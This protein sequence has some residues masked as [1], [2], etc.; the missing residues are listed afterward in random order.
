MGYNVGFMD[1]TVAHSFPSWLV[2]YRPLV[3][4]NSLVEEINGIYHSFDAANYDRDHLEIRLLWPGLWAGMIKQLPERTGWRILDFGCGTGFEAEQVLKALGSRIEF[5]AAYDPSPAMLAQAQCRVASPKMIV[6]DNLEATLADGPFNLLIT[7]SVLHH[8]P[9]IDGTISRLQRHLSEDAY[10]LAGNEPS[11]RFYRNRECVELFKQYAAYQ[12]RMK[13][14]QPARYKYKLQKILGRQTLTATARLAH[15]RGLF[16]VAPSDTVIARLVDF[17]VHH[18]LD[19][20]T[21][22]PGLE[23]ER[24]QSTMEPRWRLLWSKTYSYLGAFSELSAPRRWRARARVL[25]ER[26][27]SDG[28]NFCA[29]WGPDIT[30]STL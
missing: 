5:I 8:L 3:P 13:W 7:N 18:L 23:L 10:W 15:E 24:M 4:L 26:C 17:H 12:E 2:P 29:V 16:A 19:D 28:A 6:R 9:D 25:G 14:F 22:G 1:G 11:A 30:E 20:L 27:P 21:T